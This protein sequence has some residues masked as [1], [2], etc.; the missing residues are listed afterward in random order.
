MRVK[1]YSI[2][3][4]FIT[5]LTIGIFITRTGSEAL[6]AQHV[7][8]PI[9]SEAISKKS[10]KSDPARPGVEKSVTQDDPFARLRKSIE[11]EALKQSK[12]VTSVAIERINSA[13][14]N[15]TAEGTYESL[16]KAFWDK[17]VVYLNVLNATSQGRELKYAISDYLSKAAKERSYDHFE[18]AY[19]TLSPGGARTSVAD[20]WVGTILQTKGIDEAIIL[21][22]GFEMREERVASVFTLE[23]FARKTG[24]ELNSKQREKISLFKAKQ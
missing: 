23:D 6:K 21:I 1:L 12:S 20:N 16:M 24:V 9:V 17:P 14:L 5:V 8:K 13:R 2:I 19:D 18:K 15:G 7:K 11:S 3:V 4:I 22:G 10:K